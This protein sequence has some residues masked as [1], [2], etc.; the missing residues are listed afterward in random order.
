SPNLQLPGFRFVPPPFAGSAQFVRSQARE[1]VMLQRHSWPDVDGA[2]VGLGDWVEV[3]C[4]W[5]GQP[6]FDGRPVQ[7]INVLRGGIGAVF[8]VRDPV[9]GSVD[10]YLLADGHGYRRCAAPGPLN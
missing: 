9:E 6:K 3:F 10:F 2:P 5:T 1:V 8:C 4:S 7:V